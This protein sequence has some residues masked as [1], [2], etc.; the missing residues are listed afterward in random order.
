MT[1]STPLVLAVAICTDPT[2]GFA[3]MQSTDALCGVG[4]T[5]KDLPCAAAAVSVAGVRQP[6]EQGGLASHSGSQ[7][8][9]QVAGTN[10]VPA[11][12]QRLG[13]PTLW[14]LNGPCAP[15]G[16]LLHVPHPAWPGGWQCNGC[17]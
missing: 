12:L 9:S 1:T 2:A 13:L 17:M 5:L 7:L 4:S 10:C 8:L 3:C 16:M 6:G 15:G 11:S 14:Q